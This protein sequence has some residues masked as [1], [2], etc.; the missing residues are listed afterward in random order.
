MK[1]YLRAF[2]ITLASLLAIGW[3]IPVLSFQGG[4]KSFLTAALVLTLG[5]FIVKPILNLLILPIN[6]L[7]LGLSRWLVN[8]FVFYLMV[9]LVPQVKVTPYTFPGFTYSGFVFPRLDL[10][11]FWTLVLVCFIISLVTDFLYWAFKK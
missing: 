10:P 1:K 5:N 7:T 8:V 6:L 4:P 3:I 2:L 11:F 9:L